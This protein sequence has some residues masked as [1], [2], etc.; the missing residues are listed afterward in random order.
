MSEVIKKGT[1]LPC[2]KTKIFHPAHNNQNLILLQVFEGE[3]KY[4]QD[5]YLLGKFELN[6]LPNKKANEVIIEVTFELDE[7]SI[8]TVTGIEKDNKSN[9]NSIVI[10]NDKGGLSRNEIENAKERQKNETLG[11]D[12]EPAMI[13]E[14]NYKK[15]INELFNKVNSL[16]D[17]AE[18][19]LTLQQLKE[20]LEKFIETFNKDNVDNFTY[21]QKMHYFLTYLFNTYSSML[22]YKFYI[23]Q[24]EKEDI[25]FKIK[26]Y[27]EIYEKRGIN[28]A[29]SLVKIFNDNEDEIFGEF[30]IQLL[31]FYSQRAT[32]FYSNNEKKNSKH[33]LEEAFSIIKKFS[34]KKRVENNSELLDRFNSI[35]YNCDE[36]LNIIKAESIEKYCK[37]F[38]K[39]ILI[40][41]EDY[42][43]EEE[44]LD[45]L[46]RFK[47]AL[48]YLKN[49]QKRADKLLK[50][51]YLANIVKIEYK[52]FNS[53]NYDALLKMIDD[54]I[55]LKLGVPEGCST[56]NL[57]WFDEICKIKTEIEQKQLIAK[58]NP[59]EAEKKIKEELHDVLIELDTKFKQ[60]KFSFFFYILSEHP[61]NGIDNDFTFSN[62]RDLEN[63]YNSDK[64]KFMKKLRRFYNPMRYKGNK[65]EEQKLHAIMQEI[66]MKL[67]VFE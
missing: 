38:S 64:K 18:Q 28:F 12:L 41:E 59:K 1:K 29:A 40:K 35:L 13:I 23:S 8:L 62:P 31:S 32:E 49:P 11:I 21:K 44:K 14:R 7:D 54:C 55:N 53:N 48:L 37:S 19:Y 20:C 46:D 58:E 66:S 51:I 16:T 67:N 26:N 42:K 27:L 6:N 4:V 33:F 22:N 34:M 3:N 30:C 9:S 25:I 15:E 36:L 65:E 45:I 47:D 5:N 57:E 24:E 60:G 17:Q 61:P 43:T 2:K 63:A 10:K 50:A 56:P 52:M 39:D